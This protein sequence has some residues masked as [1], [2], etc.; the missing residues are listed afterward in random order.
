MFLVTGLCFSIAALALLGWAVW[1]FFRQREK[2]MKGITTTGTV[3]ELTREVMN[4]GSPGVYCPIVE[5]SLPSGEKITFT[6]SYGTRPAS[7]KI[8]QS[9][10]VRYDPDNPQSADI[11]STV[12][13][14]LFPGILTFM[15]VLACCL[16]FF[17]VLMY[18]FMQG[19]NGY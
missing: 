8:G 1:A 12:S 5:F 6:S 17:F 11:D 19:V 14:W 2:N 7:H 13:F 15:G 9:V 4:P 18:W 16:G 3:M 10:T